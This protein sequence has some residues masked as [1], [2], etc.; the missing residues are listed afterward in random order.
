MKYMF[1]RYPRLTKLIGGTLAF[2]GA[3]ALALGVSQS[4]EDTS[5]SVETKT[6]LTS[7]ERHIVTPTH[8]LPAETSYSIPPAP[9]PSLESDEANRLVAGT[10]NLPSN[11]QLSIFIGRICSLREAGLPVWSR[12]GS[13][14]ES[15]IIGDL[16]SY[17]NWKYAE[18]HD[19]LDQTDDGGNLPH[20]ASTAVYTACP[21]TLIKPAG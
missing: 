16:E 5:Q 21:Q 7:V 8:A 3:G 15:E 10:E 9:K 2:A 14:P 11:D 4:G 1:N 6:A 18:V 20:Y 19:L 13:F 12:H 17:Y